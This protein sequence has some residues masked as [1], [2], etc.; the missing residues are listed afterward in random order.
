MILEELLRSFHYG[1]RIFQ[2]D[3]IDTLANEDI[4]DEIAD[5]DHFAKTA[6]SPM[7]NDCREHELP[8]LANGVNREQNETRK[9][10]IEVVDTNSHWHSSSCL[11]R[12]LSEMFIE[13]DLHASQ[14]AQNFNHEIDISNIDGNLYIQDVYQQ[15]IKLELPLPFCNPQLNFQDDAVVFEILDHAEGHCTMCFINK[16]TQVFVPCGH[17]IFCLPCVKQC[18]CLQCPICNDKITMH[19]TL[20][21]P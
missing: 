18:N 2:I 16:A 17:L 19:L 1:D 10:D 20:R 5:A 6:Y 9:A 21:K 11:T 4:D 12:R 15:M 8:V 14:N 3:K 7:E 13:S